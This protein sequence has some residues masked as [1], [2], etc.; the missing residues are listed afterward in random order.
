LVL[1]SALLELRPIELEA[2][3][4]QLVVV[5]HMAEIKR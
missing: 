1:K 5:S 2:P 4:V 3:P